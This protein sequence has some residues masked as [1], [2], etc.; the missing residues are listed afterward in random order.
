MVAAHP[1]LRPSADT[2][3]A[4]K[5]VYQLLTYAPAILG[6]RVVERISRGMAAHLLLGR[7]QGMATER[8]WPIGLPAQ[9]AGGAMTMP[10][11]LGEG[12]PFSSPKTGHQAFGLGKSKRY[13][14]QNVLVDYKGQLILT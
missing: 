14:F 5:G 8:G 4:R 12:A 9:S 3:V 7:V 10:D 13:H 11:V 2:P 6:T 1:Y